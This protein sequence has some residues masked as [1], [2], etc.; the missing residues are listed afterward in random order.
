MY[1]C[2]FFISLVFASILGL[3]PSLAQAD[4]TQSSFVV[5]L[6][7]PKASQAPSPNTKAAPENRVPLQQNK[8]SVSNGYTKALG[9]G[10]GAPEVEG[11]YGTSDLKAVESGR[12]N[13]IRVIR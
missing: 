1:H 13:R 8:N 5:A 6:H 10:N 11:T 3:N 9:Q 2:R 7:T 12:S 4:N